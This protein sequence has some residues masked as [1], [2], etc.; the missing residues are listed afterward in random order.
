MLSPIGMA[1]DTV[2]EVGDAFLTMLGCNA[3]GIMLVAAV[4]GVG[5]QAVG[6]AGGALAFCA[7]MIHG[8]GVRTVIRSRFPGT[9]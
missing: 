8:E 5:G 9:G 4:A 7:F 1:L 6:M 3:G 2:L